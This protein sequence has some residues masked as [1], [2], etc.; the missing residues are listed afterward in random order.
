VVVVV[1][2]AGGCCGRGVDQ[3]ELDDL[4]ASQCIT[5]GKLTIDSITRPFIDVRDQD[6]VKSW[7]I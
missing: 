6:L 1:V 5:C 2:V 7:F 3:N 4:V